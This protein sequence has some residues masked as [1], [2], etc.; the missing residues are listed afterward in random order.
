MAL[1]IVPDKDPTVL[2]PGGELPLRVLADG[3]PLANFPLGLVREG[4][5]KGLLRATDAA[6]RV[7]FRLDRTG[8]W[9]LRGTQV[10]RSSKP[11]TDW[12]SDFATLTLEVRPR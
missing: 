7:A 9:L 6:G 12:E 2:R 10:R 4:D 5:K 8:R 11:D 3:Q 1:E